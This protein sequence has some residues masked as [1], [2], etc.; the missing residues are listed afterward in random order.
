L[1]MKS[2]LIPLLVL[3]H[4]RA[5]DNDDDDDDLGNRVREI[6]LDV[7]GSK[8]EVES[9]AAFPSADGTIDEVDFR[10]EFG[11]SLLEYEITYSSEAGQ[12]E[13]EVELEIEIQEII[14]FTESGA[15]PGYQ[16]DEDTLVSSYTEIDADWNDWVVDQS[17]STV[18]NTNFSSTADCYYQLSAETTDNV[19]RTVAYFTSHTAVVGGVSINSNTCKFDLSINYPFEGQGTYLAVLIEA[20]SATEVELDDDDDVNPIEGAIIASNPGSVL[21]ATFDWEKTVDYTDAD[22]SSGTANVIRTPHQH[23]GSNY[24]TFDVLKPTNVYWDPELGVNSASLMTPL[25]SLWVV[26]AAVAL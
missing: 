24:Y 12:M 1:S 8:F 17:C 5:E 4:A 25:L 14:E 10:G 16:P 21:Q 11:D 9:E 20:I 18:Q 7:S 6:E 2:L 26:I 15:N 23:V 22:G 19:V 13:T 3:G